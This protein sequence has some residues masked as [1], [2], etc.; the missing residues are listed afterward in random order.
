[1]VG[2]GVPIHDHQGGVPAALTVAGPRHRATGKLEMMAAA[3]MAA[4]ASV[5]ATLGFNANSNADGA[6]DGAA[7]RRAPAPRRAPGTPRRAA[8]TQ[9][10]VVSPAAPRTRARPAR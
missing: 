4:A 1:V 10:K 6:L 3:A 5:S 2:V 7:A 8:L 9:P